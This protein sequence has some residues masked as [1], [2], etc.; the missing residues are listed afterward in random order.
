MR[1]ATGTSLYVAHAAPTPVISGMTSLRWPP[2]W[3]RTARSYAKTPSQIPSRHRSHVMFSTML[4]LYID[5]WKIQD[6]CICHVC[7]LVTNCIFLIHKKGRTCTI[8]IQNN[9]TQFLRGKF[10]TNGF[11]K[12]ASNYNRHLEKSLRLR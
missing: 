5:I 7:R 3:V 10:L 6:S 1:I 11:F 8:L 12:M 9:R 2:E 4:C